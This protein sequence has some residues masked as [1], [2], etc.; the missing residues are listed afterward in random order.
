M[1]PKHCG[2][3][4]ANPI[5]IINIKMKKSRSLKLK[6]YQ[7]NLRD[8]GKEGNHRIS[9]IEMHL[10]RQSWTTS[11]A[12]LRRGKLEWVRGAWSEQYV[13]PLLPGP[14][15]PI[16]N[17]EKIIFQEQKVRNCQAFIHGKVFCTS[18]FSFSIATSR[19][20]VFFLFIIYYFIILNAPNR[21]FQN[22]KP[23]AM[24]EHAN[25]YFCLIELARVQRY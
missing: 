17:Q 24:V 7:A 15:L 2:V 20:S 14:C 12:T 10:S 11:H 25:S 18:P 6:I 8:G 5:H 21:A 1:N 16:Q 9:S 22:S 19:L 4:G 3:V 13:V 23:A